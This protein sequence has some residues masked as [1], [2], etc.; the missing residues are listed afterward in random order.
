MAV[1]PAVTI[2][3]FWITYSSR[4][5]SPPAGLSQ[6][7]LGPQ[8][9]HRA[10]T[11]ASVTPAITVR[12]RNPNAVN[13]QHARAIK[14]FYMALP[15]GPVVADGRQ[16][17]GRSGPAVRSLR[18]GGRSLTRRSDPRSCRIECV[19]YPDTYALPG[20]LIRGTADP[21]AFHRHS[22]ERGYAAWTSVPNRR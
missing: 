2:I 6:L 13:G 21:A 17:S 7:R 22:G 18:G 3:A 9:R 12:N 5:P 4:T 16:R 14:P 11:A 20:I 10:A 1:I 15:A 8:H 19:A